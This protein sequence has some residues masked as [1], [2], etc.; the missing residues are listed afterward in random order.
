[1]FLQFSVG[2]TD[3]WVAGR[4]GADVQAAVGFVGQVL[5]LFNV[6]GTAMGVGLVAVIARAEGARD[7]ATAD[8]AARQGLMLALLLTLPL[9]AAGLLW[10]PGP[11]ALAFL[12]VE[13]ARR[14]A[15]LL[16]L[17][18]AS[19][20]PQALLNAAAAVFRARGRTGLVLLVWGVTAGLNLW[21]VFGLSFGIG[22]F[23]ALG[24]RG[25]AGATAASSLA[26][27]ALAA[28]LVLLGAAPRR[29]NPEGWR[30]DLAL[31]R[32]LWSLG[33][34]AGLLQVGWNLGSLALYAILGRLAEG[35]VAESA[36][37]TNGLRIEAILYLPAFALNMI[38]A[39]LVAQA[40]GAGE[41]E[42]AARAG[43]RVASAAVAVL[44]TLALPGFVFSRELAGF[45]APDPSV[46]EATHLYLRFNMVSQPFMALSVCLGGGLQGAGD[47]R[48]TM[49]VV[50]G[51][52]W[53][54]RIP[55][56]L[57]AAPL[58]GSRGVWGAMVASMVLQGVG[59]AA[60]FRRGAWKASGTGHSAAAAPR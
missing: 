29:C 9:A 32:R 28:A 39:V 15:E 54:V 38:T 58:F 16:P 18:A 25:I 52:L 6:L 23:P 41:P 40:L 51:S 49:K 22:P 42:A 14:A 34:P 5:F 10:R 53:G 31:A 13:V 2:L 35:A 48:G 59:V 7:A 37:L 3:A 4:F 17:Y 50:L 57:A 47:T 43:W 8:H 19:L 36:A 44:G 56:A 20:A 21:W 11:W 30:P 33:W 1:M 27:A 26:G 55:L 60:R 12:P 46:R 24:P 45:L